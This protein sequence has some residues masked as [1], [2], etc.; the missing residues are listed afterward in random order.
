MG[1]LALVEGVA[2]LQP[3]LVDRALHGLE[4]NAADVALMKEQPLLV[5]AV[6]HVV[7]LGQVCSDEGEGDAALLMEG[8]E[9]QRVQPVFA[10]LHPLTGQVVVDA[11]PIEVILVV[12]RRRS[13]EA[14]VVEATA[15][16]EGCLSDQA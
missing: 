6:G 3:K 2:G 13:V 5:R 4:A 11:V 12:D 16:R 9:A 1:R 14:E 7:E 10:V 8:H 15:L